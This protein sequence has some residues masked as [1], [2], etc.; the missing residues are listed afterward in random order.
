M[1]DNLDIRW[2]QR[3]D[4]Y[5]NALA[6]LE[7]GLKV[8]RSELYQNGEVADLIKEGVIQRFEFTQELS[9]KV[10]KD[11][12]EY[13]G[14]MDIKGPRDAIK[15]ALEIG[16]IDDRNWLETLKARNLTS[17]LYDEEEFKNV[18]NEI[19]L[20]FFPL[21]LKFKQIMEELKNEQ[22]RSA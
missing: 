8:A 19:S 11:Y 16:I 14:E 21:F 13:Q 18:F 1:T 5:S 22:L 9:W 7:E 15:K 6:R 20:D 3:L 17:H 2:I 12:V 10:M 4:S